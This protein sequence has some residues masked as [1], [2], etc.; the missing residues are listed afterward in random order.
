MSDPD[1]L[2]DQEESKLEAM[3]EQMGATLDA[4]MQTVRGML[5]D[6]T[7][8][9]KEQEEELAKLRQRADL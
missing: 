1:K 5:E 8:L 2:G 6:A 7:E 3:F 9:N 4:A